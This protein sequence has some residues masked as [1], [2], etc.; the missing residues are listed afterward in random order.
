MPTSSMIFGQLIWFCLMIFLMS[1]KLMSRTWACYQT[2]FFLWRSQ[3][4]FLEVKK[5]SLTLGLDVKQN[6]MSWPIFSML[7]TWAKSL[8]SN[9]YFFLRNLIQHL[10]LGVYFCT[11]THIAAGVE[12]FLGV[13]FGFLT[14]LW[15]IFMWDHTE[16]QISNATSE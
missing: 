5:V 11:V 2:Q 4:Q 13:A 6:Q 9:Q 14:P 15:K 3:V 12:S 10:I 7:R 1:S 8:T 16:I